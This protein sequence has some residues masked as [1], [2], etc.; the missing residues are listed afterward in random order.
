MEEIWGKGLIRF[1]RR[2]GK[3]MF[4]NQSV[5][6]IDQISQIY[7]AKLSI[8]NDKSKQK[9][10]KAK[11]EGRNAELAMGFSKSSRCKSSKAVIRNQIELIEEKCQ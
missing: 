11:E 2:N 7:W 10:Q 4:W 6:V 1:I 5:K 8:S 9:E 3:N